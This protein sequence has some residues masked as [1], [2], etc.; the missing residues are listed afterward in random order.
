MQFLD[1][2]EGSDG[3]HAKKTYDAAHG[4]VRNVKLKLIVRNLKSI[5]YFQKEILWWLNF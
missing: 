1:F 5:K 4:A 3:H 2:L